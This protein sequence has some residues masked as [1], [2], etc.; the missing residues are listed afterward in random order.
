MLGQK[1][2]PKVHK[3]LHARVS[4]AVV[5]ALA[6]WSSRVVRHQALLCCLF[7]VLGFILGVD[8][9]GEIGDLSVR[10]L[11]SPLGGA[12]SGCSR[13]TG[14]GPFQ[15][16]STVCWPRFSWP[17][18]PSTSRRFC[19]SWMAI[20]GSTPAWLLKLTCWCHGQCAVSSPDPPPP[21]LTRLT[22]YNNLNAFF[23]F[24]P[25]MIMASEHEMVSHRLTTFHRFIV[26]Q[27]TPLASISSWLSSR[28]SLP[29]TSGP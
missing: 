20:P 23:L 18:T 26:T 28:R 10:G 1:T 3:F 22:L 17:S 12:T 25:L 15:V 13:L 7:L 16:S 9:E 19:P 5:C 11:P 29:S 24:V 8:Q 14:A 27:L 6:D 2:S 4:C 21:Q